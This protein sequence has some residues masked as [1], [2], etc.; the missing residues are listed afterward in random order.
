MVLQIPHLPLHVHHLLELDGGLGRSPLWRSDDTSNR[1]LGRVLGV[2]NIAQVWILFQSKLSQFFLHV[3]QFG[4]RYFAMTTS[5]RD[6]EQDRRARRGSKQCVVVMVTLVVSKRFLLETLARL[7][8]VPRH[9]PPGPAHCKDIT[10]LLPLQM[11]K[12]AVYPELIAMRS[13]N[14]LS[15]SIGFERNLVRAV[16][17]KV[18]RHD[19]L[20]RV[21][22]MRSF[23]LLSEY[24]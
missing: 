7:A 23:T 15:P 10:T 20:L 12:I 19:L 16:N 14:A 13:P 3:I 2:L 22:Q 6:E 17:E 24:N 8:H 11:A 4:R 21:C 18:G 9:K 5:G 1:P